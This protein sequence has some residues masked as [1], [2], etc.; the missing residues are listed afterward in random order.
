MFRHKFLIALPVIAFGSPLCASTIVASNLGNTQS[1]GTMFSQSGNPVWLAAGFVTDSQAYT[2][3]SIS[4]YK[5]SASSNLA[6]NEYYRATLYT[7]DGNGGA[8]GTRVAV[9]TLAG[10]TQSPDFA[11]DGFGIF[12]HVAG[13]APFVMEAN[14]RYYAVFEQ[15]ELVPIDPPF[16]QILNTADT[17]PANIDD[18]YWF[19]FLA[20]P[21]GW[22]REQGVGVLMF[23][24]AGT[25]IPEPAAPSLVLMAG[26]ALLGRRQR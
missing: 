11:T 15:L 24:V 25:V 9:L 5:I 14:T 16:E 6:D 21:E 20:A 4:V 2:L 8:P 18:D 19:N 1:T 7:S 23:E 17:S 3:D 22:V 13:G 12:T 26:M 10:Y